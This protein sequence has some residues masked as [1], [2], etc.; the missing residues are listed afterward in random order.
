MTHHT[1]AELAAARLVAEELLQLGQRQA[2]AG[3]QV[4]AHRALGT[5]AMFMG[6]FGSAAAQLERTITIYD[7]ATH[8]N[9]AFLYTQDPGLTARAFLA[10]VLVVLGHA[11]QTCAR[12]R[13]VLAEARN[14]AHPNT[15]AQVLLICCFV[16][17][18]LRDGPGVVELAEE[19]I[20]LSAEQGFP[21]WLGMATILKGW[22]LTRAEERERGM[23]LMRQGLTTYRAT[24]A[25]NWVPYFLALLAGGCRQLDQPVEGLDLLAEALA[26]VRQT[27]ERWCE[28]ELHRLRGKLLLCLP[29]PD[30]HA[31]EA[32][33]R[34]SIA[35]AREQSARLWELRAATSLARLWAEQGKRAQAHD[36]LAPVYGWFTEG[37]DTADLK[38]A[39]ALLDALS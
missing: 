14:L 8:G 16:R 31:A 25:E 4:I 36:L 17:H 33:F 19:L 10:S 38:D 29:G 7:P 21:Y 12:H 13:E 1:R 5:G 2:N 20:P 3:V 30:K 9:L 28:A 22:A 27:R 32:A 35:V 11:D 34:E 18:L 39:R 23:D 37:F 15:L 24:G 6:E 26:R